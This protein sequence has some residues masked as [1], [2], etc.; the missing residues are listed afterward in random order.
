MHTL[1]A[2]GVLL[3]IGS[4]LSKLADR[5]VL[6]VAVMF[7]LAGAVLGGFRVLAITPQSPVVARMAEYALF[8]VLFTDGMKLSFRDLPGPAHLADRALALGLPVTML[9]TAAAAHWI[10]GLTWTESFLIGAVLSP[11]DPVLVSAIVGAKS[12]PGRLR[13]MLNVESGL[14]DGL[15]LPIVVALLSVL[16]HKQPHPL[17][18]VAGVVGGVA[19]GVGVAWVALALA[20][21]RAF[22]VAERYNPL[23]PFAIALTLLGLCALLHVNEFL[24]AFSAGIT[25]ASHGPHYRD[26]FGRFGELVAEILKLAALLVFGALLTPSIFEGPAGPTIGF[27]LVALFVARPVGLCLALLGVEMSAPEFLTVAWFGPKGFAS[28][29]YALMILQSGAAH[30]AQMFRLA[31]VVI[32]VSII[33]QSSTDVPV[34]NWFR[35]KTHSGRAHLPPGERQPDEP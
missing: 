22:D 7:L 10:S 13:H 20:R 12:I 35:R 18:L 21:T 1:L 29:L 26:E 16:A 15:A 28:V 34:A 31:A 30:G 11:T 6:S 25:V 9:F 5:S 32:A 14:N 8:A 23:F 19:A 4:L 2:F 17:M 3:L 27:T 24:A 33:A